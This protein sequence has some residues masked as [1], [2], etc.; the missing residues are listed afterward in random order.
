MSQNEN[1]LLQQLRQNRII[2]I[3]GVACGLI[4]AGLL[5]FYLAGKEKAF[6]Q[7]S[8]VVSVVKEIRRNDVI[9]IGNLGLKK[10]PVRF[11]PPN[12]V[13]WNEAA[14]IE[15]TKA[16]VTLQPGQVITWDM[17]EITTLK[18]TFSDKL[19]STQ[20]AVTMPVDEVSG[21]AGNMIPGDR[22][23]VMGMFQ[24]PE[25]TGKMKTVARTILQCVPVISV[26][27]RGARMGGAY[28]SITLQVSPLEAEL[29]YFAES[30]GRLKYLLRNRE[31]IAIEDIGMVDFNNLELIR[32]TAAK[33]KR[34]RV[35]Y[36]NTG[37][38]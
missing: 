27:Y 8:A 18:R 22:V 21:V 13:A 25:K 20:R 7:R 32:T 14:T 2:L 36:G 33:K 5:Y 17:V 9:T 38:R 3:I 28:S 37:R 6:R 12:A 35:R 19:D 34:L 16:L 10:I 23:D 31:N 24:I 30:Q 29:L 11:V 1:D 15:G 4:G 26:G